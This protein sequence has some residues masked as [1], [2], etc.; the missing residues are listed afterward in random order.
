MC[1]ELL[2]AR[3]WVVGG[4]PA[5]WASQRGCARVPSPSSGLG[6]CWSSGGLA[7]A[8]CVPGSAVS[9]TWGMA[10]R[11]DGGREVAAGSSHPT[12]LSPG[13]AFS[14]PHLG[15]PVGPSC[16]PPAV[17]I[18]GFA[19]T[20]APAPSAPVVSMRGP[21]SAPFLQRDWHCRLPPDRHQEPPG[22]ACRQGVRCPSGGALSFGLVL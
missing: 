9:G 17:L 15:A 19:I 12:S 4:T 1:S 22:G 16:G 6:G 8:V 13:H 20:P 7:K 21:P 18:L 3:Q 11:R 5:P 2:P 14:L 10:G